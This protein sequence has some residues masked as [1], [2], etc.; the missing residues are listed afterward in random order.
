MYTRPL[1][2]SIAEHKATYQLLLHHIV[3]RLFYF[4]NLSSSTS[5]S[6]VNYLTSY[7]H[8]CAC[9][10]ELLYVNRLIDL[11]LITNTSAECVCRSHE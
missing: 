9:E 8:L 5:A 7:T 1:D 3:K 4:R 11:F 6:L 2:L 10:I